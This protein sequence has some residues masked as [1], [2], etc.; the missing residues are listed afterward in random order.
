MAPKQKAEVMLL[1][2]PS[3]THCTRQAPRR[4][5]AP[6][7]GHPPNR[8]GRPAPDLAER[9][10]RRKP[11]PDAQR[12]LTVPAAPQRRRTQQQERPPQQ[13]PDAPRQRRQEKSFLLCFNKAS[14][15]HLPWRASLV[16]YFNIRGS[17]DSSPVNSGNILEV[18]PR[19]TKM[20]ASLSN[21]LDHSSL[22]WP[23]SLLLLNQTSI[24]DHSIDP[25]FKKGGLQNCVL[26]TTRFQL[27]EA[28]TV[29]ASFPYSSKEFPKLEGG[30][31][32]DLQIGS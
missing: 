12:R 24:M 27:E 13:L 3:L 4:G 20:G 5:G 6:R 32:P 7:R 29:I 30:M 14:T 2:P 8:G 25:I 26:N 17:K 28:R 19:S 10:S 22:K 15:F 18:P 11:S 21:M 16:L 9:D 1:G 23:S 31:K